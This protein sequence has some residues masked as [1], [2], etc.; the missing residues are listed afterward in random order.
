MTRRLMNR[1]LAVIF[2]TVV[3]DAAGIALI[4][5]I[6]PGLLRSMTGTDDVSSLFG[7]MLA[8]YA[9]MQFVFAPVLGV[10][11]DRY[12]RR[13]V[14]LLSLAGAAIDYLIMAFTPHLWLL[15][16]G[17]AVAGLTAANTAVAMAYIAD[18]TP[19]AGRARRYGLFHAFFGAG[20]VMGP[21]IG[22]ALGDVSVRDP[23]LAAAALNGVN[24][25]FALWMLPE[26]HRPTRA[27]IDWRALNPFAPLRWALSFRALVPLL[28]VFL[29][30]SLVGQTYSTVWVLF[31]EDRFGWTGTEVGV[32]LG[33]F[34]ALVALAQGFAVGPVTRWLGERGT[35]LVGIV[36]E[37][38]ALLILAFARAS[39]I[40]FA[41]IPLLAFGGIG[42]PAL[43][44]LQ[45]KAVDGE[46]QG[47]LQGVVA[48]FVS[49]AAIFGP[50]VFSWI[51]AL[52]RPGW[53]GLVWI[54]GVAIYVLA[55]PVV[56]AVAG[57]SR[58]QEMA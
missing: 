1:P 33:I 3:L 40:A 10:L 49:L 17:R 36:C 9:L 41:L 4:F 8:L 42:L 44:S 2:A 12:G 46:R 11:S 28:A 24:L 7:A 6:L 58:V 5:P 21:V 43:R 47:Q 16:A 53:N 35:L 32:S 55:V 38:A 31:V 52:S 51:Y 25:L 23:F 48:S 13:P 37:A 22:G 54:V 27:S 34:G 30:I 50:L 18:I 20:F 19:E 29:L 57:R 45:S 14:L 56:L 26:S 15:F 39:W